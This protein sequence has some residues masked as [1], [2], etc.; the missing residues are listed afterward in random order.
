M[1]SGT[2]KHT[3]FENKFNHH[4]YGKAHK[5]KTLKL[6]SKLGELNTMYGKKHSE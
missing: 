4:M 3:T 2:C 1:H 6:I 5:E